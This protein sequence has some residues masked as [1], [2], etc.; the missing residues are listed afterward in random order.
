MEAGCYIFV[1]LFKTYAPPP[2]EEDIIMTTTIIIVATEVI[3][4]YILFFNM[5][6]VCFVN[7]HPPFQKKELSKQFFSNQQTNVIS[8]TE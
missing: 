7:I 8:F 4:L 3:T 5:K 1:F 2:V 6:D